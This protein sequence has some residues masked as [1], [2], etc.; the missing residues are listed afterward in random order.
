M[1][2]EYLDPA[3]IRLICQLGLKQ[4]LAERGEGARRA[5]P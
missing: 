2:P 3:E 4:H 1:L 5:P